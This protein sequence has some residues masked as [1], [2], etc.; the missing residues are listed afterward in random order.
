MELVSTAERQLVREED[1][2]ELARVRAAARMAGLERYARTPGWTLG[3]IVA[4]LVV[5]ALHMRSPSSKA[6]VERFW[7]REV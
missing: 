3:V 7:T 1:R 5:L 2:V 4:R 6:G